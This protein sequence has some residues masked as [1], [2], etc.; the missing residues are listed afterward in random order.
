MVG[1]GDGDCGHDRYDNEDGNGDAES[2]LRPFTTIVIISIKGKACSMWD[3][4]FFVL[5]FICLV[6][7]AFRFGVWKSTLVA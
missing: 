7:R 3:S 5:Q 6:Q 1:V 4:R 2:T